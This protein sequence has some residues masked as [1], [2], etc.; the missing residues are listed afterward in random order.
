MAKF[1]IL[2]QRLFPLKILSYVGSVEA[3]GDLRFAPPLSTLPFIIS[4]ACLLVPPQ[5]AVILLGSICYPGGETASYP[6]TRSC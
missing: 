3:L 5:P 1:F 2:R 4:R 6:A